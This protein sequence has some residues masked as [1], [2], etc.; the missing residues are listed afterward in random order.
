MK[1][2]NQEICDFGF[3]SFE[4]VRNYSDKLLKYL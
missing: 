1:S 4:K 2:T 3:V